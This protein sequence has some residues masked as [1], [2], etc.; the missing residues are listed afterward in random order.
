MSNPRNYI[1]E[2]LEKNARLIQ[3]SHRFDLYM[4]RAAKVQGM[5][6]HTKSLSKDC[7][8]RPEL[9][10]QYTLSSIACV[11]GYFRLAV[12][13]LIDKG[14]PFKPR[15]TK[16][17]QDFKFKLDSVLAIDDGKVSMGSLVSHLIQLNSPPDINDH[18]SCLLDKDFFRAMRDNY[19]GGSLPFENKG[20]DVIS[21][22]CEMFRLRHI[23]AHELATK[24][25]PKVRELS[26]LGGSLF[27]FMLSAEVVIQH[28][29]GEDSIDELIDK[30]FRHF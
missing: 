23:F 24:L 13:N 11:E 14:E 19:A 3:R 5:F 18:M 15:A 29:T 2:I 25:E 10:R 12:A 8:F 16:L 27:M 26:R 21:D 30:G 9:L 6:L 22:T 7:T 17:K 1:A 4:R 20:H 28:A